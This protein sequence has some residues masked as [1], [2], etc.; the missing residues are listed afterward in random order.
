MKT[1]SFFVSTYLPGQ[2]LDGQERMD[3]WAVR[4]MAIPLKV[5]IWQGG[6]GWV[7]SDNFSNLIIL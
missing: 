5:K 2:D 7:K 6:G 1:L 3:G 4:A